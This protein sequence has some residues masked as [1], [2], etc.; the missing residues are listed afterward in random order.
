MPWPFSTPVPIAFASGRRERL[1]REHDARV[2]TRG[3]PRL[4]L[5]RDRRPRHPRRRAGRVPRRHP[6]SR[7]RSHRRHRRSALGRGAT[8]AGGST[9]D[10]RIP[11]LEDLLGT[12][13]DV[14]VNID[15]KHDASVKP[16]VEVLDTHDA[17]DRVCIGAFS[18]RRLA[19]FRRLTG[20]PGVHLDGPRRGGAGCERPASA[21]PVGRFAARARAPRCPRSPARRP[22]VDRRFVGAAH[23][24]ASRCTSGRSTTRR[25]WSVCSTS[26]STAS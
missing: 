17:F 9:D 1:P 6:R 14:R 4:P 22:L 13:P 12:W 18:D 16:L 5:H 7:H 24:G 25:R 2:P 3:R 11:L 15:P 26:G 19:R 23:A 8:G 20:G 10:D 21:L